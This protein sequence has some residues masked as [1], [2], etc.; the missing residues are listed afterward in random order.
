MENWNYKEIDAVFWTLEYSIMDRIIITAGRDA[1]LNDYD[2]KLFTLYKSMVTLYQKVVD[3]YEYHRTHLH[4]VSLSKIMRSS[5]RQINER[6]RQFRAAWDGQSDNPITM[7]RIQIIS[8]R[9]ANFSC[10]FEEMS[11]DY[12]RTVWRNDFESTKK[13]L[14]AFSS[15]EE[16]LAYFPSYIEGIKDSA[17][18]FFMEK[19]YEQCRVAVESSIETLSNPHNREIMEYYFNL[20]AGEGEFLSN[21]IHTRINVLERELQQNTGN[22]QEQ[23]MVRLFLELL[24]DC[25]EFYAANAPELII[26]F[27]EA[28]NQ[29]ESA[30]FENL[31]SYKRAFNEILEIAGVSLKK[32]YLEEACLYAAYI[33]ELSEIFR[34]HVEA[35]V[36]NIISKE[37]N[38]LAEFS[39]KAES[40]SAMADGIYAVFS[41]LIEIFPA[42]ELADASP[43]ET[44]I[45]KAINETIL[46]KLESLQENKDVFYQTIKTMIDEWNNVDKSAAEM[47]AA[48]VPEENSQDIN[49]ADA[50]ISGAQKID[51]DTLTP[52]LIRSWKKIFEFLPETEAELDEKFNLFFEQ[53]EEE[54]E[55]KA[56]LRE[57]VDDVNSKIEKFCSTIT[58][59]KR[60][61]ILF[62]IST[63]EEILQYSV[64][65]L[66]NSE[67]API[68]EY[69][70]L[71]D[72]AMENIEIILELNDIVIIKPEPNEMFNGKEHDVLMA[73]KSSEFEKGRIIKRMTSGY[74]QDGKVLLRANVIAAR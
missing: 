10:R 45:A 14:L 15:V 16:I 74:K 36:D 11:K 46:I 58:D 25:G 54:P 68:L 52:A 1:R 71:L 6:L 47:P 8:E 3:F 31:D 65:R 19:T 64:S 56:L 72:K 43:E 38:R 37:E 44:E 22:S 66:R 48:D 32:D 2:E 69:A 30:C 53:L 73:E 39:E 42:L 40:T 63:Y 24:H 26:S 18:N 57:K 35:I 50:Q 9:A 49:S 33:S 34:Q 21:L 51:A 28:R 20:L 23:R 4:T 17:R 62:E 55:I 5:Y 70:T 60:N 41:K 61:V 13:I 12:K 59:L 67:S 29:K 27:Q 7:E